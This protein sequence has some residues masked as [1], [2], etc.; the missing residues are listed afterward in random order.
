MQNGFSPY[1]AETQ[2]IDQRRKYAELL[3]QQGMAPLQ[4]QSVGGMTARI[5]P[6]EGLA[7]MLNAYSGSK[8]VEMASQERKDL[9][10]RMDTERR[11]DMAKILQTFGGTP[12]TQQAFDPQEIEQNQDQGTPMPYNPA[13]AGNPMAAALLAADSK[14]PSVAAMAPTLM[15]QAQKDNTPKWVEAKIPDGKGGT[16]VGFVNTNSTNPMST[17][18][19]G[20]VQPE[21]LDFVN[22]KAVSPTQTPAGTVVPQQSN[23]FK[24]LLIPGPDGKPTVN[25]PLV[26]A[27]STVRA[28]GKPVTTVV[29]AGGNAFDKEYGKQD[30][31]QLGKWRE[32]ALAGNSTLELVENMRGAIKQGVYSGGGAEAKTYASNMIAGLTGF[33]PKEL[34]G[35]QLFNAEA[36]K[37]VLDK[38]KTLGANPSNADREFIERTIP[39]IATNPQARDA[40]INFL[41]KK[42]KDQIDLFQRADE[43]ARKWN[44]LK[45]FNYFQKRRASDSEPPPGAVERV[46]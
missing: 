29:N 3:R 26:G 9:M 31:E 12:Q 43:H 28:A 11:T 27:Q 17:F 4:A 25:A 21:K 8:G 36:S 42:A 6:L 44:G 35:S 40:L 10:G 30:A 39:N 20:G 24:D 19:E 16:R 38:I 7:K 5:S 22:G 14:V 2:D 34:P 15:A 23:P 1:E 32:G 13:V 41:E 46:N 18:Q 37:L 45:G 33:T